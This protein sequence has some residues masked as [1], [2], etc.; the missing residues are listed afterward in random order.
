[1]NCFLFKFGIF[2]SFFA[3]TWFVFSNQLQFPI[4][5]SNTLVEAYREAFQK[6]LIKDS[7]TPPF[8]IIKHS[9]H[10]RPIFDNKSI[11]TKQKL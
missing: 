5:K 6:K 3:T 9:P 8:S 7:K 2:G 4:S 10:K 11:L 1:M